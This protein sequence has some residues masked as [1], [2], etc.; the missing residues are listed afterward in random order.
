MPQWFSDLTS[1]QWW[2][3][4]RHWITFG[5]GLLG[6][7]GVLTVVQQHDALGAID[8]IS[9]GLVKLLE[10]RSAP[11]QIATGFGTLLTIFGPI[12]NGMIAS[13]KA[14][15]VGQIES[16]K[17]L[18]NDPAQPVAKDAKVALLTATATLPELK[19]KIVL[20]DKQLA[21]AVPSPNVV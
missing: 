12:I 20:N 5:F 7:I 11:G 1:S 16:V 6:G 10:G 3:A 2:A 17:V 21:A 4:S 15:P 13:R 8:D 9:S 19:D 18:T 14:S